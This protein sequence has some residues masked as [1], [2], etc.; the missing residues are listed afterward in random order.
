MDTVIE[1]CFGK[2]LPFQSEGTFL[3]RQNPVLRIDFPVLWK[4]S[5]L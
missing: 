5:P 3:S 4:T 1:G 2:S